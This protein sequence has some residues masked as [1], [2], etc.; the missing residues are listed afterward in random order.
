MREGRGREGKEVDVGTK[1]Y[2]ATIYCMCIYSTYTIV[3]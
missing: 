1:F 2:S 3:Q